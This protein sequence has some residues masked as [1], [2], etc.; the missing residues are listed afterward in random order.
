MIEAN[1]ELY[2]RMSEPYDS[3]EQA[4]VALAVFME[5][6]AELRQKHRIAEVAIVA[7]SYAGNDSTETVAMMQTIGDQTRSLTLVA[8]LAKQVMRQNA[9]WHEQEAAALR[10]TASGM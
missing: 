5:G 3:A 4:Q 1:P 8:S 7:A 6:V 10:E 9:E 2:A